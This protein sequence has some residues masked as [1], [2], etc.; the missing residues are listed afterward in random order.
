MSTIDLSQDHLVFDDEFTSLSLN[1]AANPTGT[2]NTTYAWGGRTLTSNGEQE[3]YSDPSVGV[4]PF[5]IGANGGL[6]ITANPASAATQAADGGLP[7]TSGLLTTNTTF[8]QTYGYFEMKAELPAG[9]GLW[10]AFWLL[11]TNGS[12]PPEIDVMEMLGNQPTTDYTTL[13]TGTGNT[14]LGQANTVANTTTGYHTYGVDWEPN[15][16]TF[17]FDGKAVFSE[18]TPADMHSPMYMLANLAVGGSWPGDPTAATHFPAAMNIDYIRAYASPSTIANVNDSAAAVSG[19]TA[20][21][22]PDTTTTASPPATTTT[23][24]PTTTATGSD[25]TTTHADTA[26]HPLSIGLLTIPTLTPSPITV[27]ASQTAS[28]GVTH[29]PGV[30]THAQHQTMDH[31]G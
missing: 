7:Y 16:T 11:A 10:P 29:W 5:S 9:T 12:W 8:S 19:A 18:P 17:Y 2:W 22:A 15:T 25:A 27:S 3:Y 24:P 6:T 28:S 21:A 23:S 30:D 20:G 13:H 4:N 14:A 31:W 26:S 1:T